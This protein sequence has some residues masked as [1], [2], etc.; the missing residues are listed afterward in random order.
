MFLFFIP[1]INRKKWA[2]VQLIFYADLNFSHK[3]FIRVIS[4]IIKIK[5]VAIRSKKTIIN[6]IS[7][8]GS[9]VFN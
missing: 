9:V 8:Y 3:K 7:P 2:I 6:G 4:L 1:K 5:E